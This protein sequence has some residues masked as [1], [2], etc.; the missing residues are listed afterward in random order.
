[1]SWAQIAMMVVALWIVWI[2]VRPFGL[3]AYSLVKAVL[4]FVKE[5]FVLLT[6]TVI[7]FNRRNQRNKITTGKPTVMVTGDNVFHL[8]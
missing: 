2:I 3:L 6:R 1:M 8:N 5:V 4:G 7:Y